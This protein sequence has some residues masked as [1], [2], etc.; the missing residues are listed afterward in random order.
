MDIQPVRKMKSYI[1]NYKRFQIAQ[2]ARYRKRTSDKGSVLSMSH[3][4]MY[5][6]HSVDVL[7]VGSDALLNAIA[8][9]SL[10]DSGY[11]VL[12]HQSFPS[13]LNDHQLSLCLDRFRM[14][15]PLIE[16]YIFAHSNKSTKD[17]I[18]LSDISHDFNAYPRLLGT[19][20]RYTLSYDVN[21]SNKGSLIYWC[22]PV[23]ASPLNYEYLDAQH[24]SLTHLTAI[25]RGCE[26]YGMSPRSN[27]RL[28]ILCSFAVLTTRTGKEFSEDAPAGSVLRI[29]DAAK[30]IHDF[31]IYTDHHRII[32]IMS[33]Y[34]CA[35]ML[36]QIPNEIEIESYY[37]PK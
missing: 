21:F 8:A 28:S 13:D 3:R 20:G 27:P 37:E 22:D 15:S 29:G 6:E 25:E 34:S 18:D 9:R 5:A 30:P 24:R 16:G 17:I 11:T 33:A 35:K 31:S 36:T 14:S 26:Q 12:I 10:L 1:P 19:S 2:D 23:V 7:V 32:D 4:D